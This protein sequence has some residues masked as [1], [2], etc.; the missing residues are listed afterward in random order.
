MNSGIQPEIE[1][2]YFLSLPLH[3]PCSLIFLCVLY[4]ITL[5][6]MPYLVCW[7]RTKFSHKTKWWFSIQQQYNRTFILSTFLIEALKFSCRNAIKIFFLHT[8]MLK[9]KEDCFRFFLQTNFL[10]CYVIFNIQLVWLLCIL[11]LVYKSYLEWG[12]NKKKTILLGNIFKWFMWL[13]ILGNI[14]IISIKFRVIWWTKWGKIFEKGSLFKLNFR[15][16]FWKLSWT[17]QTL[18]LN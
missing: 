10:L 15:V 18:G 1:F 16:D 14:I 2:Y 8:L 11:T 12:K 7:L 13:V 4:L 17:K 6:F 9:M 5:K 3:S